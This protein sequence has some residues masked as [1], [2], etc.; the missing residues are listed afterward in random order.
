MFPPPTTTTTCTPE[1]AHLADL[2]GHVLHR[3]GGNAD[4]AFAAERLAA[5][6][7]QD[8]GKFRLFDDRHKTGTESGLRIAKFLT[9]TRL[10]VKPKP[11][12]K[13]GRDRAPALSKRW[14]RDRY[15]PTVKPWFYQ[16]QAQKP[17]QG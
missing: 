5:E 10:K 17:W 2:F 14:R 15:Q 3:L 16:I 6:L 13:I 8:P 4:A 9:A 11:W 7:E 12:P 1:F